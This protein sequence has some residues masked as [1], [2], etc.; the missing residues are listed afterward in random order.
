MRCTNWK[1]GQEEK[2]EGVSADETLSE[3]R[4]ANTEERRVWREKF[5]R[6]EESEGKNEMDGK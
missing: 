5:N 2:V 1:T 4:K 3:E 6:R